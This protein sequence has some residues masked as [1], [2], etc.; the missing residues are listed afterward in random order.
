MLQIFREIL[1]NFIIYLTIE[2]LLHWPQLVS[3]RSDRTTMW[4]QGGHLY[5]VSLY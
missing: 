1:I 5:L 3:Q 2:I 4:M